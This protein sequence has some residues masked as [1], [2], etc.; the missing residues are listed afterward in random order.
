M[1]FADMNI[2][3]TFTEEENQTLEEQSLI[4]CKYYDISEF[5]SLTSSQNY[6]SYF[7]LNNKLHR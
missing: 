5:K 2:A 3:S 7:H 6:F 1:F 4:D